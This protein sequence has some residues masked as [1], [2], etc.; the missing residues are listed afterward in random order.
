MDNI[1]IRFTKEKLRRLFCTMKNKRLFFLLILVLIIILIS[2]Y[3][4]IKNFKAK[5]STDENNAYSEY[6]PQEE[7]SSKQ[8]RE[9]TVSLYFVDSDNN[10]KS[11]GRLIDSANL[12]QNP[13][14]QLIELLLSGTQNENLTS[15][16]PENT[17]LLDAKLENNCVI[18]NFSNEFLNFK[19]D[20]QKFNMIN[21]ALNTL[22]QLNEV[23]SVKIL[24]EGN[25]CDG[26]DEFY[27]VVNQLQ[28]E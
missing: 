16:F 25:L 24:V 11:E 13:Y 2:L 18:L 6:T 1:K 28:S 9:T 15:A 21:C 20:N 26:F 8:M 19:D 27:D 23:N 3:F 5:N 14:K 17:K 22:K 12:L 10:I 7:I 4:I